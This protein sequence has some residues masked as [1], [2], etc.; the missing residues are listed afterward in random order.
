MMGHQAGNAIASANAAQKAGAVKRVKPGVGHHRSIP[1]VVQPGRR[2]Q[3]TIGQPKSV[4]N[5]LR[6]VS[7]T[8]DMPPPSR[9]FGQV[10]LGKN[11]RISG[12]YHGFEPMRSD[13]QDGTWCRTCRAWCLTTSGA[14]PD[15]WPDE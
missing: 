2:Y 15:A 7:N 6:P 9:Q 13:K 14:W 12:R 1:D 4:G 8:L 11:P 5:M 10:P 3:G